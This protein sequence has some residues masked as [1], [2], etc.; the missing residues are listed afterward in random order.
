[1]DISLENYKRQRRWSDK[2]KIMA[3]F[4]MSKLCNS[5]W[6]VT[7]TAKYFGVSIALVSENIKIFKAAD[8]NP[9]IY[10]HR[11]REEVLR[12]LK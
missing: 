12:K 7:Q 2:V 5:K 11:T 1:M 3:L 8:T 6:T 10:E 9:R 4:H